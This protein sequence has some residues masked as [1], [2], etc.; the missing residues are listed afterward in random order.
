MIEWDIKARKVNY[1]YDLVHDKK[2]WRKVV[3]DEKVV[4]RLKR[5]RRGIQDGDEKKEKMEEKKELQVGKEQTT[6]LCCTYCNKQYKIE[7][8]LKKHVKNKHLSILMAG[9]VDDMVDEDGP[10]G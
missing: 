3:K 4:G 2:T 10:P 9:P 6:K 8:W 7:S 1:W 5:G